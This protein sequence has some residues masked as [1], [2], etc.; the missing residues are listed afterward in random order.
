MKGSSLFAALGF[1]GAAGDDFARETA[2]LVRLEPYLRV[3]ERVCF[4]F[5]F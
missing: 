1:A 4:L 5:Y 2:D 3:F